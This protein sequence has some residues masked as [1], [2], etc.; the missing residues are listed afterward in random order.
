LLEPIEGDDQHLLVTFL[1]QGDSATAHVSLKSHFTYGNIRDNPLA[2]LFDTDLWFRTYRLRK[3]LRTTYAF[4]ANNPL[5]TWD[6]LQGWEAYETHWCQYWQHDP[7]NPKTFALPKDEEQPNLFFEHPQGRLELPDAPLQAFVDPR[8]DVPHG[9]VE[10]SWFHSTLL[11]NERRIWIYTPPNYH[12]DGAPYPLLLLFDGWYYIFNAPTTLDNLLAEGRIPELVAVL[13][14]NAK[15]ARTRE[16]TCYP[17]FA[18]FLAQELLPWIQERYHITTNPAQRVIAG[19]SLGGLAATFTAWRH[20]D[21]FGNVLSQTGSYWWAPEGDAE[22]EWLARQVALSDTRVLRFYLDVG[23]LE[24]K[25]DKPY[26]G[27]PTQ[28]TVN[29]HMRNILYAKGYPVHYVEYSGGHDVLV[30]QGTLAGGLMAL[31]GNAP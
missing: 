24:D 12:P 16:L 14:D 28:L 5:E 30:F 21:L 7:L 22:G 10:R 18:D 26:D 13:V 17:P 23:R 25:P 15:D 27:S 4:S 29:R 9:Q 19:V 2:R 6:E 3:D 8:A 20:P 11:E 31:I 1:W